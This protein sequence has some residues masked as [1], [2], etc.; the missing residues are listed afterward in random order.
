MVVPT[1]SGLQTVPLSKALLDQVAAVPWAVALLQ[2]PKIQILTQSVNRIPKASTED[3]LLA[4]TLATPTTIPIW[5]ALY[6]PPPSSGVV[7]I[8]APPYGEFLF[9][10]SI[11]SGINGHAHTLHGGAASLLFDEAMGQ[12]AWF[13]KSPGQAGFTATLTVDYKK[14]IPTPTTVLLRVWL[15]EKSHGRKEWVRGVLEDGKGT[16]Y[17]KAT[18][19]YLEVPTGKL[20][21][22]L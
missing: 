9:I 6:R 11:G 8:D 14:P 3:S 4:E 7:S 22:S 10:A 18:A 5:Q 17:A 19:L 2:E 12:V 16:L 15:E 21:S 13:H 20:T 1:V